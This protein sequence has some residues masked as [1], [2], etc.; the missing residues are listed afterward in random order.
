MSGFFRKRWKAL[1]SAR[2]L[3]YIQ[4]DGTQYINTE[5]NPTNNTRIVMDF[6]L[7]SGD[8]VYTAVQSTSDGNGL[9]FYFDSGKLRILYAT[10][11]V[12]TDKTIETGVRCVVD[13]NK[14]QIYFNNTLV[15]TFTETSFTLDYPLPIGAFLYGYAGVINL[16][17]NIRF[18]SCQIYEND[19]LVHDML[20]YY[21]DE[22][23]ACMYDN[24]QKKFY[25]NSGT[26]EFIAGKV[27]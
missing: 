24:V 20:P 13:V 17:D 11:T 16:S 26:G 25:Y 15:H 21:D 7:I 19:V 1:R 12:I 9:G 8:T 3:E 23:V 22:D 18:Y 6:E 14:N 27:A 2:R 5:Y 4:S 10:S